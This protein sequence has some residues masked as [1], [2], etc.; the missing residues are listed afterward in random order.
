[1]LKTCR[2]IFVLLAFTLPAI[3]SAQVAVRVDISGL[4][5]TLEQNVRLFLSIE[6]QKDHAMMTPGRLR[7][8]H[9]KADAEI[10]TA[11][12]PYG[13]YRPRIESRLKKI[14]TGEWQA[15]YTIDAGPAIPIGEF[16]LRIGSPM[17]ED[18]ELQALLA[19]ESLKAGNAFSHLDY[20]NFKASLAQL[21]A[22]RGYFRAEFIE[23]RVEIDLEN[24]QARI[25]LDF[26]SGPRYRFGEVRLRQDMLETE[27][28]SR[29]ITFKRGDP[30]ELDQLIAFQ[31]TLNDSGYFKSV[32][33][34]PGEATLESNEIPIDVSLRP[35][36]PHRYDFGLGYG[37]DTGARTSF[38]WQ[39]PRVNRRGHKLDTEIRISEIGYSLL[40]NYRVPVLNPRTDQVVYSFGEIDEAFEDSES[41]LR[42]VGV[43][44]NHSRG[45]WRETLSLN[46]Q[47]EDFVVADIDDRT[48]L[49]IPGISWSRTWGSNFI[50]ALDGLRF[51]ISLRGASA[52]LASDIDFSQVRGGIK[53]IT[54]LDRRNRIIARGGIGSTSTQEFD[55]LPTSLRFY[56]GGAQTVRGYAYQSLGP[57]DDDGEVIGARYMMFGGIEFEHYFNDRWGLALFYDAGNAIDDLGDDLESGAGFGWRWK[58]PVG[59]VRIDLANAISDPDRP[60]RL[61]INIGPDL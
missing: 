59:P 20:E 27:L 36:K 9:K 12:Q 46:Y 38:G 10:A 31:Q 58:S 60:W 30:Y 52:D 40:A 15:S 6:Q 39:M 34:S 3:A 14:D 57:T 61:H 21:A 51:D 2:Q 17:A 7:R 55:R 32:E 56:A 42:R 48:T 43:S 50:N 33:I 8:L 49:L 47:E 22:E 24:Y 4:D 26:E 23:Q 19:A 53:F 45:D 44:L 25:A 54:S 35:R 11:L 18:P 5:A 1:M 16:N 37:T 29:Y 13:H 28:L 41:H